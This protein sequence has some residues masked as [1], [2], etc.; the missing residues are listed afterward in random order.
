M[1]RKFFRVLFVLLCIG[2]LGQSSFLGEAKSGET[3][4]RMKTD[5]QDNL[6]GAAKS[7]ETSARIKT[8]GQNNLFGAAKSAGAPEFSRILPDRFDAREQGRSPVV[9][10]QGSYGTCWALAA[11]SALEA[12]LLPDMGQQFSADHMAL[13]NR[14]ATSLSD[15]GD[16]VMIMAYLSG[17]QGPVPEEEDP[18]GDAYSPDGLFPAVHVQ[19][20]R[21]L[22]GCTQ[23]EIKEA[24][25]QYGAVQTS[26]YMSRGETASEKGYYNPP[27]A[28]WYYPQERTQNHDVIILGWDDSYSRFHFSQVPQEDGAFICQNSWG[29]EFGKDGI[30][31][32]SYAD[33][34]IARTGLA[35]SRIE[36]ADNY[37]LLY[38]TDD[39]GWVGQQGYASETCWFA[40]VYTAEA[41]K[42]N[43]QSSLELSAFG[44]YATGPGTS[45]EFYLVHDFENTG[46]FSDMKFLGSAA[47]EQA[48]FY[49]ADLEEPEVLA[50]GERFAMIVKITTPNEKNPVAVEY[51]ADAWSQNVTTEGKEGYLSQD[52][53]Y[54][55]NTEKRFGSN[56][57]LKGYLRKIF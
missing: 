57:C 11:T 52:G 41:G 42:N 9:K 56:V 25:F 47:L 15:G 26:L 23:E 39:C 49:T 35:Y 17:W 28:A 19:E 24:V 53:E 51:P 50:A 45:C 22:E 16:Y 5:G 44:F 38:Q 21:L 54:W 4:V 32:V 27:N 48:G 31:Y 36:A 55:E 29:E 8:D 10:S 18:Y 1:N 40:N 3:S 34:N 43:K 6:F 7:G 37:D 2:F 30:F 33:A 14:F 20:I 13:N 46:S 12:A